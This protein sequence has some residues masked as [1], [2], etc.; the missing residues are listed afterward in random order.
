MSRISS[1]IS[2]V[3]AMFVVAGVAACSRPESMRVADPLLACRPELVTCDKN[4][5][6]QLV[7]A[8]DTWGGWLLHPGLDRVDGRNGQPDQLMRGNTGA[9]SAYFAGNGV[10]AP[11]QA[12]TSLGWLFKGPGNNSGNTTFNIQ[13]GQQQGQ[14]QDTGVD[15]RT[16][17]TGGSALAVGEGGNANARTGPTN[18]GVQTN[19]PIDFKPVVNAQGFGSATAGAAANASM[20]TPKPPSGHPGQG[21]GHSGYGYGS[22]K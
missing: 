4:D 13:Q 5:P 15:V 22:N 10:A 9:E 19:V 7:R 6:S 12:G 8:G 14:G 11:V 2:A 17:S 21:G 18:V 16:R 3:G 20:P 1:A